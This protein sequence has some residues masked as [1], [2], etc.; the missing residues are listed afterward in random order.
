MTGT[1]DY[2]VLS[3]PWLILHLDHGIHH[4]ASLFYPF[5]LLGELVLVLSDFSGLNLRFLRSQGS[6]MLRERGEPPST[7]M[8]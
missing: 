7:V 4:S 6:I 8:L 1:R 5:G 2:V 3:A